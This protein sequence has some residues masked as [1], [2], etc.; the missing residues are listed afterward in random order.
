MKY[1]QNVIQPFSFRV[2]EML[3]LLGIFSIDLD[4]KEEL[5]IRY[6]SAIGAREGKECDRH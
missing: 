2:S 1:A 5:L 4:V 3:K 6:S